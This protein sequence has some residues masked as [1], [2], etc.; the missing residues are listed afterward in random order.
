VSVL[1]RL[2]PASIL[3]ILASWLLALPLTVVI[4]Q[5]SAKLADK[6]AAWNKQCGD[7]PLYDD[8]CTKKRKAISGELGQ[9]V[10]L[11]NDELDGLRDISPEAT[12]DFVKEANGRRKIME[13]EIRNA[14]HVI[15][16]LGVP[17]SDTQCSAEA[18]AIEQEKASLE[19][20]YAQ[21]HAAFD[22]KWISLSVSS[23]SASFEGVLA[24][25]VA[26]IGGETTGVTLK[27]E[28]NDVFELDLGKDENLKKLAQQLSGRKVIVTGEYK[29]QSGV[30]VKQRRIIVVKTLKP[31]N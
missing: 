14:L 12:D 24:T 2:L 6:V 30:E 20:E 10:A 11:V 9:F 25:G 21:T 8:A 1:K 22:G 23:I 28:K 15:K 31:V 13:L 29:P 19:T 4:F 3:L 16:C 26:A 18:V 27:T 17:A 7:K 5:Q